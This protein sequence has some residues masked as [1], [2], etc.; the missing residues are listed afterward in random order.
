[1]IKETFTEVFEANGK[2]I[3]LTIATHYCA[4]T[5]HAI[6]SQLE[7]KVITHLN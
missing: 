2:I 1:M 6:I 5:G 4:Q 7:N 3:M